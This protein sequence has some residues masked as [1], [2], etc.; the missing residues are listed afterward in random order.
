MGQPPSPWSSQKDYNS[1]ACSEGHRNTEEGVA[2][3]ALE[4]ARVTIHFCLHKDTSGRGT[5]WAKA[6]RC[7]SSQGVYYD[8]KEGYKERVAGREIGEVVRACVSG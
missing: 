8:W 4:E 3:S 1:V 5:A 2:N 6:W 7:G